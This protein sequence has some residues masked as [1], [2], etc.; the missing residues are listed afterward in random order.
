MS[1]IGTEVQAVNYRMSA[2][3]GALFTALSAAQAV[4]T[5]AKK[6]SENPHFRSK[7]SDLASVW[8]ACREPLTRNGF[9]VIQPVTSMSTTSVT[10]TTMLA[11]KS[12]EWIACDLTLTSDKATPQG[13]GSAI[14]YARRYGLSAM[15]GIAPEDDDGNAA[16]GRALERNFPAR[17]EP[18]S[19]PAMEIPANL[20]KELAA[21][22]QTKVPDGAVGEA[23]SFIK[24]RI[25]EVFPQNGDEEY[26]RVLEKNGI[27]PKGNTITQSRSAIMQLWALYNGIKKLQDKQKGLAP[28]TAGELGVTDEDLPF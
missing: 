9:C 7:Y 4:M 20:P 3:Q 2:T 14:T 5:G 26:K 1:E 19:N 15:A 23:F 21:L 25:N 22:F 10:V 13:I 11:H 6:D 27:G 28:V 8:D 16:S 17:T 12:G 24:A 18:P